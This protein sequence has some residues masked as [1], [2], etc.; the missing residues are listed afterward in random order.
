M[1]KE[2]TGPQVYYIRVYANE[3]QTVFA[4]IDE[5][6]QTICLQQTPC[7]IQASGPGLEERYQLS[8][9]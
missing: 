2:N 7:G 6:I 9:V 1:C 4:N 3:K 8:E 5:E